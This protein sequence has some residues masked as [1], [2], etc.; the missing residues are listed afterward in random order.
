M[1]HR[2]ERSGIIHPPHFLYATVDLVLKPLGGVG[3]EAGMESIGPYGFANPGFEH[4][5]PLSRDP[6]PISGADQPEHFQVLQSRHL[7][8]KRQLDLDGQTI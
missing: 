3:L 8:T 4:L 5:T 7:L 1:T 6:I 2:L